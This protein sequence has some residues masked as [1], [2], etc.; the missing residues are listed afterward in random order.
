MENNEP[1]NRKNY[2]K[3]IRTS[4]GRTLRIELVGEVSREE[5]HFLD[6]ISFFAAGVMSKSSR[7]HIIYVSRVM[8]RVIKSIISRTVRNGKYSDEPK[9]TTE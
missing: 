5:W 3:N 6:G 2:I 7:Q 1:E 9:S 8:S 4:K